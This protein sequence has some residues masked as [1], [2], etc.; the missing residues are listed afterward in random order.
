MNE[1]KILEDKEY[2]RNLGLN[3]RFTLKEFL[4]VLFNK[5][6]FR[7]FIDNKNTICDAELEFKKYFPEIDV[8]FF[9]NNINLNEI[10]CNVKNSSLNL[11][12]DLKKL[13]RK[14]KLKNL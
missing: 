13:E 8:E 2:L 14:N 5:F 10:R 9:L 3:D 4:K 6:L 7:A 1:E 11:I 12:V